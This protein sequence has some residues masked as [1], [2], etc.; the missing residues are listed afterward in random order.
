RLNEA[1]GDTQALELK[2]LVLHGRGDAAGAEAAI[3]QAIAADPACDWAR[4]DLTLLMRE[5]GRRTEAELAARE[6]LAAL[7]D[8]AQAH[9]QLGVILAEQD[10]LPAAEFHNRRALALAGPHPQTLLNLGLTLYNQGRLD[11]AEEVLLEVHRL[12]PDTAM[13][14]GHI[15]RLYEARRDMQ[16]AF[17]WLERAE[18][19]AR[20]TGEDFTLLRALYLS[21]EDRADEAL[22]LLD[23]RGPLAGP[24]RLDR[25]RLLDKLKR[26]DEA[27]PALINAKAQ[28]AR[29]MGVS[30]DAA[31]VA[32][33]YEALC[34]FFTRERMQRLPKARVRGDVAQPIFVMGFPRSGTTMLE[35]MLSSHP[36]VQAGGELPFV[37]E[38]QALARNILPGDA[39]FP[40]KLAFAEAADYRHVPGLLRDYYLGRAE[41]YGV[42][43]RPRFTD[44]MPLNDAYLPLIQLAFPGA[45]VIRMVRHPFDIA[46][47]VLSHNL[48]HGEK[49]GYA[50]ETV[51]AHIQATFAL[52]A[53]YDSML[54]QPVMVLRYEDFVADQDG[55]TR[56]ILGHC[57]LDYDAMCLRFHENPRHAPTP[58]YAQV[59]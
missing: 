8:D 12:T 25:A 20:Q 23:S 59:S 16:S 48:T 7:P 31:K 52:N 3:R 36:E 55:Q 49:C 54:D 40:D 6:A 19:A 58:S 5:T 30:Y 10:D 22:K 21:Q 32:A 29:E 56:R 4:N 17:A 37:Y 51:M 9:L 2:A 15:S 27:W 57:G 24:A 26:Y 46:V 13:V 47:S 33:H 14:M 42:G 41:T 18:A 28:L 44:K 45:P 50:L 38:W 34:S 43:G 11:E 35:Q 39:P 53:Y 1:P